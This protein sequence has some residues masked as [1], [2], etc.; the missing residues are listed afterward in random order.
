MSYKQERTSKLIEREL[1]NILLHE[2]KDERLKYVTI[3]GAKLTND[4]SIA[5]V[6]YTIL[7]DQEQKEATIKNLNDAKGFL[8]TQ[9]GNNLE[10]RK[11]P[12]LVFKYD[13]SIEYGNK[14]DD[15]LKNINS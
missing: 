9:L 11:V 5:T 6:Y 15:I 14:I 10:L 8:K 13:E 2:T 12:E 3:T 4:F 7:G 1:S